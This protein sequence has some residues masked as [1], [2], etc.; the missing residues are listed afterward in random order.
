MD[1]PTIILIGFFILVIAVMYVLKR[2]KL[3]PCK[4]KK[5]KKG[6]GKGKGKKGY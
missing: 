4:G 3:M 5:G 1:P 6:K 2:G